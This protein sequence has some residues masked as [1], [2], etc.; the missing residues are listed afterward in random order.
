MLG[1]AILRLHDDA[2]CP[3]VSPAR[4][5]YG[6]TRGE[7]GILCTLGRARGHGN[8]TFKAGE[9]GGRMRVG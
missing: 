6:G 8:V 1:S 3:W 2:Q 5:L 9:L 7:K 4:F